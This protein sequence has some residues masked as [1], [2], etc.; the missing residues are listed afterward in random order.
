VLVVLAMTSCVPASE[1]AEPAGAI[2]YTLEPSPATRGEVF[3]T[4]DGWRVRIEKVAF[5]VSVSGSAV[6]PAPGRS[7]FGGFQEYRFDASKPALVYARAVSAGR[8]EA[9][10]Y[11][12]GVYLYGERAS[13]DDA[14]LEISGLSFADNARFRLPAEAARDAAYQAYAYEGP[15]LLLAVRATRGTRVV[16]FDLTFAV[17]GGTSLPQQSSPSL[18]VTADALVTRPL[19]VAIE[20]L[21]TDDSDHLLFDVF[22][23][24]DADR[25]GVISGVEMTRAVADCASACSS[26]SRE[27][28]VATLQSRAEAIFVPR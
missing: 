2:G 26:K 17:D 18:E 25:D 1:A 24:A 28:L 16:T 7:T 12:R 14:N 21:F 13:T 9:D 6:D 19:T 20:A 3:E 5:Q 8:A 15:S 27:S 4:S 10:L 23:D 11:F 22:A